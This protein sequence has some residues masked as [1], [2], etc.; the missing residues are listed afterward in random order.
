MNRDAPADASTVAE[1]T[2]ITLAQRGHEHREIVMPA[3]AGIQ[4]Y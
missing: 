1:T 2:P 3:K 4:N